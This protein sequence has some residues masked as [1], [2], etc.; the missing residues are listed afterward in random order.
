MANFLLIID[1]E[2]GRRSSTAARAAAEI[3]FLPNLKSGSFENDA[4][5]L[6]W[7]ASPG[8]PVSQHGDH[9]AYCHLFG[10]PLDDS[11]RPNDA[12]SLA[13]RYVRDITQRPQ[14]DG[15]YAAFFY[16]SDLGLRVEAD[17][18]GLFPIYYCQLGD[19]LLVGSSSALFGL[20]PLFSR[21]V[22]PRGIAAILLTSGLVGNDTLEAKVRRLRPDHV[23]TFLTG[24]PAHERPPAPMQRFLGPNDLGEA[25]E[26][27]PRR[28]TSASWKGSLLN[29]REPGPPASPAA[30][31]RAS[32]RA[33]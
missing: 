33:C 7:A 31:I 12:A 10:E 6:V 1:P 18:L 27:R 14:L 22:N 25:V 11:G 2:K 21:R 32:L 26:G 24:L 9:S 13:G 17:V 8:A 15:F 23:L 29:C 16:D 30:S 19:V 3:A 20:H 5:S 28:S 4:L